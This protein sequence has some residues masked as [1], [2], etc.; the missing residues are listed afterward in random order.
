MQGP[1]D[2][3][4]RQA[5]L[6]RNKREVILFLIMYYYGKDVY[7][8]VENSIVTHVR[9][10]PATFKQNDI[11]D[12]YQEFERLLKE[13]HEVLMPE[14][15]AKYEARLQQ[16]QTEQKFNLAADMATRLESLK[17]LMRFISEA[18]ETGLFRK[19]ES[20][21]SVRSNIS[22]SIDKFVKEGYLVGDDKGGK[23]LKNIN[24]TPAGTAYAKRLSD[25]H[26]FLKF[27][28][29]QICT[30]FYT[31]KHFRAQGIELYKDIRAEIAKNVTKTFWI[32]NA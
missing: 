13:Q 21:N 14:E 24:F 32:G 19:Y 31:Y 11:V 3:Y 6:P 7:H 4:T 12:L 23:K 26:Y 9:N 8:V 29:E 15:L 10:D 20:P 18:L 1:E 22:K 27:V 30:Y 17:N 25:E 28:I 5:K 16:A 2:T